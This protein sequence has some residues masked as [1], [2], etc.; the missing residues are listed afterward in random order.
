MTKRQVRGKQLV[1]DLK[2][3]RGYWKLKEEM[4]DHTLWRRPESSTWRQFIDI[5]EGHV[6]CAICLTMFYLNLMSL[7]LAQCGHIWLAFQIPSD[8]Y[9]FLQTAVCCCGICVVLLQFM[10][11]HTTG[12]VISY[13][14]K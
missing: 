6:T 4:V 2:K 8:V 10:L 5:W 14:E 9:L 13:F 3:R 7:V 12:F 1:D 11:A